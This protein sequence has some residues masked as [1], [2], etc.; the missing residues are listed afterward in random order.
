MNA[1][2]AALSIVPTPRSL[3]VPAL[4]AELGDPA[5]GEFQ[6]I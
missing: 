5:L 3:S 6:L 2:P 4:V 1:P